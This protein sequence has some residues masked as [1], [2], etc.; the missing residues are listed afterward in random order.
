M[1]K[2]KMKKLPDSE[3]TV[4][5]GRIVRLRRRTSAGCVSEKARTPRSTAQGEEYGS[6]R[7]SA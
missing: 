3:F 4:F 6:A 5:S 2:R 1:D 7:W